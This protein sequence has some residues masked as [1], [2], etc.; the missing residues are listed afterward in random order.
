MWGEGTPFAAHSRVRVEPASA[1][2]LAGTVRKAGGPVADV[3]GGDLKAAGGKEGE[4]G[5]VVHL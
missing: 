3:D 1:F 2:M 5:I 4:A